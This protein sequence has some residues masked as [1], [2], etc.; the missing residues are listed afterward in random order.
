MATTAIRM[1]KVGKFIAVPPFGDPSI[2]LWLAKDNPVGLRY[3]LDAA[4]TALLASL[5][6]SALRLA[7]S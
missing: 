7:D 1:R 2:A 6:M 5:S 4:E 3:Y